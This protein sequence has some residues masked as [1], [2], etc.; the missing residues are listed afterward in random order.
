MI[1]LLN[2]YGIQHTRI[3]AIDGLNRAEMEASCIM[4]PKISI[5]ENACTCSHILALKYFVENMD[6]EII[7]IFEDDVSFEFLDLIPFNWS[8]L[9]KRFPNNYDIIQLAITHE[10]HVVTDLVKVDDTLKYFCST[11]YLIKRSVARNIIGHY[12][13]EDLQKIF[14]LGKQYATADAMILHSGNVFAIPIFTYQTNE[15]TIH[16]HHWY[17]HKRAKQQQYEQWKKIAKN[18]QYNC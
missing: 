12:Y 15:S 1:K 6:D 2:K 14:L 9:V 18:K 11:A 16:P 13:S 17:I 5:F 4:N 7:V 3:R 8:E 10:G